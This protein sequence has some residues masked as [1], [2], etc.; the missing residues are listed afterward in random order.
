MFYLYI[1]KCDRKYYYV[2]ITNNIKRRLREHRERKNKFT[3]RYSTFELIY[4]EEY[5]TRKDAKNRER[6][7]KKWSRKKKKVL[8]KG[9]IKELINLSKS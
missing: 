5:G 7:L 6:Q 1:L 4:K 8:I 3:K 2:G 9:N